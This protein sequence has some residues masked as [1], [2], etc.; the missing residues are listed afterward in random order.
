MS[1][2]VDV[3]GEVDDGREEG[4]DGAVGGDEGDDGARGR[5][6]DDDKNTTIKQG[7]G[8]R[9]AAEQG[10]EDELDDGREEGRNDGAVGRRKGGD[11]ARGPTMS[12]R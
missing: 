4:N 7:K 11:D 5:D 9:E 2:V 3:T 6:G 8:R 12:G 10:E 1:G